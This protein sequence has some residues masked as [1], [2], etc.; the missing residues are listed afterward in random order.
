MKFN[1]QGIKARYWKFERIC[2]DIS[3]GM[4]QF[5]GVAPFIPY[6]TTKG[7]LLSRDQQEAP[8]LTSYKG[9][10]VNTILP[11]SISIS[12]EYDE[13]RDNKLL[14]TYDNTFAENTLE[15]LL[16]D[17]AEYGVCCRGGTLI[18]N[19]EHIHFFKYFEY[20]THCLY[21]GA[22]QEY[23]F[24]DVKIFCKIRP[25]EPWIPFHKKIENS[26]R[27]P[28]LNRF[29]IDDSPTGFKARY[30]KF[31]SST[32]LLLGTLRMYGYAAYEPIPTR[33]GTVLPKDGDV[34]KY[35][36]QARLKLL[37]KQQATKHCKTCH[38]D[39]EEEIDSVMECIT[40]EIGLCERDAKVHKK[41]NPSHQVIER[42]VAPLEEEPSTSE[43]VQS[44]SQNSS[45]TKLTSTKD[46][47]GLVQY[48]SKVISEK[49]TPVI[50]G[51]GPLQQLNND[52]SLLVEY[53]EEGTSC[54]KINPPS[55][56]SLADRNGVFEVNQGNKSVSFGIHTFTFTNTS[57]SPISVTKL[58]VEYLDHDQTWKPMQDTVA[59]YWQAAT[60][61]RTVGVHHGELLTVIEKSDAHGKYVYCNNFNIGAGATSQDYK[62]ESSFP[63]EG[64]V[65]SSGKAIRMIPYYMPYPL[66]VRFT[67]TDSLMKQRSIKLVYA[68][69]NIPHETPEQFKK[70]M[71]LRD[72]DFFEE[73]SDNV[74][75]EQAYVGIKLSGDGIAL[76]NTQSENSS[77]KFTLLDLKYQYEKRRQNSMLL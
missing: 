67:I 62:I 26:K 17:T 41:K 1:G 14:P 38:E 25:N 48:Y 35:K 20:Y 13:T 12:K 68:V 11:I 21:D 5:F 56:S 9:S 46:L 44:S 71:S 53:S 2:G 45:S 6:N 47:Q 19:F 40:C 29:E 37:E 50:T 66:T 74:N 36:L 75:R 55:M 51:M 59:A 64:L 22:D 61:A 70:R 52:P 28:Y 73:C 10:E 57:S 27:Y 54:V 76:F 31:E 39:L 34:E 65:A 69:P 63:L 33:T 7:L 30:W 49:F 77:Q 23:Y 3:F 43:Q 4:L 8:H 58:L 15:G 18:V 60:V 16:D 32:S 24:S 42:V 72:E